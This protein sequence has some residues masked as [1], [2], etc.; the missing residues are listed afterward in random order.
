MR[1]EELVSLKG[2]V[3]A[4][5]PLR[6]QY[7]QVDQQGEGRVCGRE[8]DVETLDKRIDGDQW[9]TEQEVVA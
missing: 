2:M 9:L 3:A 4:L 8:G 6:S 7:V 5:R 1:W